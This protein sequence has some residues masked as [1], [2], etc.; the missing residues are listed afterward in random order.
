ME[1]TQS[2]LKALTSMVSIAN[3]TNN[4]ISNLMTDT[5]VECFDRNVGIVIHG[6]ALLFIVGQVPDGS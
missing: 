4:Q 2:G 3:N 6:C 5:C 1:A